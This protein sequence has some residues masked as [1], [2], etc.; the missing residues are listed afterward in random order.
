MSFPIDIVR[1]HVTS[2]RLPSAVFGVADASGVRELVAF[3][4][5]PSD[6]Y[7]LFSITKPIVALAAAR[8]IE[9]GRLSVQTPLQTAL[10]DFADAKT[11]LDHL[12]A[13]TSG[14]DEPALD[15]AVP[16]RHELLTR[17]RVFTAGSAVQYSTLAYS[18]IA[19]LIE[20]A[21]GRS[22]EAE[23]DDLFASLGAPHSISTD[24]TDA[25]PVPDAAD[26]GHDMAAFAAQR[27]PGAGLGGRAEELLRLGS[28]L[29][30]IAA[31]EEG[32]LLAPATLD[33]MRV[34]RTAG[35][36]R[37][38]PNSPA[39]DRD[40][41]FGWHVSPTGFGDPAVFGH[42]GWAGTEFWMHPTEGLAW[43]LLT[44]RALREGVD[45][46]ALARLIARTR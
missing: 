25:R 2:G 22:W 40:W 26:A 31:G 27:N 4:A 45:A 35:L 44:N 10:P 11:A 9:A 33:A 46:A 32:E 42:G 29:L 7:P 30:R 21:G 23:V 34:P 14:L 1:A 20:H 41:G 13:H 16:L 5:H 28:A 43:V 15:T 39:A 24:L 18:G 38:D 36:P 12:A 3:G 8:L 17:G 6:R 19:A 37:F